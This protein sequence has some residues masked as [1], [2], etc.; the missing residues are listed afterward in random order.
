[1]QINQTQAEDVDQYHMPGDVGDLDLGVDVEDDFSVPSPSLLASVSAGDFLLTQTQ[2]EAS[3]DASGFAG[4]SAEVSQAQPPGP[5]E[6][7]V[8]P[9]NSRSR[10]TQ[11]T[12]NNNNNNNDNMSER[13][14]LLAEVKKSFDNLQAAKRNQSTNER[15]GAVFGLG[16]DDLSPELVQDNLKF[17]C[18]SLYIAAKRGVCKIPDAHRVLL[19]DWSVEINVNDD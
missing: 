1:M 5:H 17:Y 6:T 8:R 18:Q 11:A 15:W 13:N 14:R 9:R 3:L 7:S 10:D 16:I 19:G 4:R 2:N 12:N